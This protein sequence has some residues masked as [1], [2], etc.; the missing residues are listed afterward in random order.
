M[1]FYSKNQIAIINN[2]DNLTCKLRILSI[3]GHR[4]TSLSV[5]IIF[6]NILDCLGILN[7]KYIKVH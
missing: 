1:I 5:T 4:D 2:S 6:L 3:Q 7:G